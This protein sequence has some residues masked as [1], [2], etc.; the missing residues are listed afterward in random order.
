MRATR[1]GV[2]PKTANADGYDVHRQ[3]A[4]SVPQTQRVGVGHHVDEL[5]IDV[6]VGLRENLLQ[7]KQ[8]QAKQTNANA[9]M[10]FDLNQLASVLKSVL[11]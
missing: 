11:D 4:D 10:C 7:H 9:I 3:R 6:D 2:V 8:K 5:R 1:S